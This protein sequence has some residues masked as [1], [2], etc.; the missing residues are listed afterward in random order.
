MWY[1]PIY[2][3]ILISFDVMTTWNWGVSSIMGG[4]IIIYICSAT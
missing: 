4:T 3:H 1:H 2:K